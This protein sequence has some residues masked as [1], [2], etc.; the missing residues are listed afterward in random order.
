MG[1]NPV[2]CFSHSNPPFSFIFTRMQS[3]ILI[4][5]ALVLV[6]AGCKEEVVDK[7]AAFGVFCEMVANEAKPVALSEPLASS[8]LDSYWED[9]QLI[10]DSY[11]V[12]IYRE[13]E[14][15]VTSLFPATVT[16]DKEV[17]IIGTNLSLI[18]YHQFKKDLPELEAESAARRFGRL[19]GYTP[20]GINDLLM[21]NTEFKSLKSY[22]VKAQI[23]HLFYN[24][25]E[26]A[27]TFY[28]DVLGLQSDNDSTFIV[29][30]ESKIQLHVYNED[31]PEGQNQSTAIALLTDQLPQWYEYAQEQEIP[32]KYSYKPRQGGPHDGFVAIDPGGYLLEFEQ[33]KQHPENELLIAAF[34]QTSQ[35]F[36][37]IDSLSFYG[38]I[39]WT[40]HNDLLR[41]QQFYEEVLGFRMVADQG[42]TKIYQTSESGFIGLVDERRGMMDY[43]DEKAVEIE[44]Q[45]VETAA[46]VKY[47]S[48]HSYWK[49]ENNYLEGPERYRYLLR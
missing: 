34:E 16:D 36:T 19:L 46:A 45:L 41:M 39:T 10:A 2:I 6:L 7:T 38:S 1:G 12:M 27:I 42:W 13:K 9:F 32:I 49:Q 23:T 24:D 48:A 15:P 40:Y 35:V 14:F 31:H 33:F 4:V 37:S 8:D 25:V 17:V 47:F 3:N 18:R 20:Q 30:S 44:W 11:D 21:K 28:R 5:V 22:G 26:E 29:G 43:A